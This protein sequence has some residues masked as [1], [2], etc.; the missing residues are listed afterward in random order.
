MCSGYVVE[1]GS[2]VIVLDHGFGAHHRLLELGIPAT[3]VTHLFFTH[4]HYDHCGDYGRLVLTHWDQG[5]GNVGELEVFGPP[6]LARMTEQLFGKDG[7]Y[8]ADLIARTQHGCSLGIYE[9]RGGHLPRRRPMPVVHELKV[10]DAV[11]QSDWRLSVGPASHF[12]PYLVTYSFRLEHAGRALVYSGDSG[13][14]EGLA[15]LARGA[16]VLIHMCHY[17]SGTQ[18]NEPFAHSC[19]GHLELAKMAEAAAVK[20]LVLTHIT[21]Q[22]DRPGMRERVVAEMSRHY[23]GNIFFGEDC[24][25]IPIAP[26]TLDKLM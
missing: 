6:P 8:E 9:A 19:M 2:N 1:I 3:K 22:F 12:Q 18:L 14:D 25:E 20:T 21:E 11:T 10:G 15:R 4:L 24:L 23:S 16:D 17:I 26:P 13:P 7:V 5:A